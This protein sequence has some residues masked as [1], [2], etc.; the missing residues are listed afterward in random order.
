VEQFNAL[1]I[2]GGPAGATAAILLAEAGWSV[3]LVERK[4]FP[5]R[6]VCGEFLSATNWPLLRRLSVAN[7]FADLAGPPVRQ[8]A[9]YVRGRAWHA[10]LPRVA[11]QDGWGR[12]LSREQLDTL[13]LAEARRR[14]VRIWQPASCL[15]LNE[16][17]AGWSGTLELNHDDANSANAGDTP[18]KRSLEITAHTVIAAHGSWDLGDLPTQHSS[19]SASPGDWLAFKA[20]FTHSDLPPGLM[21]LL[22]FDGGYGGLVHCDG[23]RVSLSCCLRRDVLDRLPRRNGASAGEAVLAH[24]LSSCPVLRPVLDRAEREGSWLSAGVIHPGIRPRYTGG[25]FVIGNAAGEAHPVVAEGISMAMQSAWLLA[26]RLKPHRQ[27]IGNRELAAHIGRDYAAAWRRAFAPRIHAAA[28]IAHWAS[29]PRLA[30]ATAPL[31]GCFPRLLTLG[32]RLAGKA[33]IVV[34]EARPAS[35]PVPGCQA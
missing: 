3:A 20:H 28:V 4:A 31:V 26:E 12:A 17:P 11:G 2:G 18:R 1:V 27:T 19:H 30:A 13:L 29:R 15:R 5:R 21:P 16:M 33:T 9:I 14:G 24:L 8:T 7:A 6:K 32:A 22:A 34:P 35:L 23:G 25:V 10:E